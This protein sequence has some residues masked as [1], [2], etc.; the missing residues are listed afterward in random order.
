MRTLFL[1]TLAVSACVAP[2][3]AGTVLFSDLGPPG[4]VYLG[5]GGYGE[6]GS[7]ASVT[8]YTETTAANLFTVAGSGSLSV[9][10]IDLAVT[11]VNGY[12]DT[13]GASLWTD[14]AGL[15]GVQVTNANEPGRDVTGRNLLWLGNGHRYFGS[16][17]DRGPTVLP[18]ACSP[19]RL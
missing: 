17:P 18:G 19:E 11:N 12:I 4:N 10:E 13:F 5:G 2:A 14:N 1:L 3:V 7:G 15:P 9:S 16:E 8:E 6:T